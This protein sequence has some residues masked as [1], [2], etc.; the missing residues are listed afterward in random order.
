MLLMKLPNN[1]NN[2]QPISN[3]LTIE[4]KINKIRNVLVKIDTNKANKKIS[5]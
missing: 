1:T 3:K 5:K 2:T 4:T